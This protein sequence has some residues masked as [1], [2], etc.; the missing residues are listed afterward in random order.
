MPYCEGTGCPT[1]ANALAESS[2]FSPGICIPEFSCFTAHSV[3]SGAT[4]S[5]GSLFGVVY[6][7]PS[8]EICAVER[9]PCDWRTSPKSDGDE[10][11]AAD[12]Q[13]SAGDAGDCGRLPTGLELERKGSWETTLWRAFRGSRV[14]FVL[15]ALKTKTSRPSGCE[16]TFADPCSK[17]LWY[18][19]SPDMDPESHGIAVGLPHTR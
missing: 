19:D 1:R 2:C 7:D 12:H 18:R 8:A 16:C 11:P 9:V 6:D 10:R 17:T 3:T 15:R 5:T 14:L 13:E 4:Q